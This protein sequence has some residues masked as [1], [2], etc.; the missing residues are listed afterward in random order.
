MSSP[1]ARRFTTAHLRAMLPLYERGLSTRE[2]AATLAHQFSPS[3]SRQWVLD[4]AKRLGIARTRTRAMEL[5]MVREMGRDYDA[6]RDT[7]IR[8]ATDENLTPRMIAR[9]LGVSLTFAR[10]CCRIAGWLDDIDATARRRG[11][12]FDRTSRG[13][14]RR[15]WLA[16]IPATRRRRDRLNRVADLR[17]TGKTYREIHRETGTP[18]GSIGF[19]LRIAGLSKPRT[20]RRTA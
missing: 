14:L 6:L 11:K 5:R 9:R 7:A 15:L 4:Q 18:L 1:S 3:P 2:I 16:N 19:L 13:M 10:R 12:R 20:S 17:R 8:L